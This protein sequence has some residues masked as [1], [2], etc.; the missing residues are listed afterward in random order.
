M[1]TVDVALALLRLEGRCLLQ[2]RDPASPV[3]PGRWEFP[4]GKLEPGE[5]P[6]S[7]LVRELAEELGLGAAGPRPL[8]P[9][10]HAYGDRTVRLHP[11]LVTPDGPPRTAL[12]WG[13]FTPAE[14]LR[15]PLPEAN[16]PLV[17][18]LEALR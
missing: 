2:R 6:E 18:R 14:M 13:W 1:T 9:L 11:F 4:G 8:E 16:L 17:A 15:L 12:A 3:L 5:A 10:V 7:A